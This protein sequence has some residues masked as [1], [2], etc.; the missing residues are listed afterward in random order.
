MFVNA[1]AIARGLGFNNNSS[2]DTYSNAGGLS[3]YDI[4]DKNRDLKTKFG[5]DN[6]EIIDCLICTGCFKIHKSLRS[7]K[8][9]LE[10]N[11][12]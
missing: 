6:I 9:L 4:I 5:I 2:T 11:S 1:S 7:I 3:A 10:L 8:I 12:L